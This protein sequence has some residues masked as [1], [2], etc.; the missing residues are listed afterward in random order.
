M[1][2]EHSWYGLI[3]KVTQVSPTIP[4]YR[5]RQKNWPNNYGTGITPVIDSLVTLKI[6]IK[7]FMQK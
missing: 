2:I 7:L 5:Q 1:L 3:F 6:S 4:F